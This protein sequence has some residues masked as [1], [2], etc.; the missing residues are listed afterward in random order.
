MYYLMLLLSP[1]STDR[2]GDPHFHTREFETRRWEWLG[3]LA[4]PLLLDGLNHPSPEVRHRCTL[5]LQELGWTDFKI[6]VRACQVLNPAA[7]GPDYQA[8]WDDTWWR[9]EVYL[10]G[11]AFGLYTGED[12]WT[13]RGIKWYRV[14]EYQDR[15]FLSAP[16]H[17]D[18]PGFL[19]RVTAGARQDVRYKLDQLEYQHRVDTI[20]PL[21]GPT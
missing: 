20:N 15:G 16:Q 13:T 10:A 3:P 18:G 14:Y 6:L 21:K 19:R 9:E 4:V 17:L 5:R 2:L 11:R 12:E 8:L 1:L 7:P